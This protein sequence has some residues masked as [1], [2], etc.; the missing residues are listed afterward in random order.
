MLGSLLPSISSALPPLQLYVEI[1]PEG[2]VLQPPPG[3][4]AGPVVIKRAITLDGGGEVIVDGEGQGTVLTI[5]ADNSVVRGLHLTN[6]GYS[7]DQVDAG[8]LLQA[9]DVLIEDNQLDNNQFGIHLKQAY[10]N[11]IRN[12]RISSRPDAPSLRGDGIRLWYSSENLIEAN[13]I[14]NVRDL[15]LSNSPD[16]RIIG[17]H[18][19][20]SRIGMEIVFSPGNLVQGNVISHNSTGIV[21]LYSNEISI[22]GNKLQHMRSTSGSA[23][24]VKGSSQVTIEDNEILHCAIGVAANAPTHPENAFSMSGNLFA[25][26]DV[27]L[28]FYGEKGGHIIHNN[29][30][31]NNLLPVAVSAPT[32]ARAN[33][34]RGNYWDSYVGFDRD[35]DGIGDRPYDLR[36]YADR[37]WMD[38][39]MTRFFRGSPTLEVID[40]GERLLPFSKPELILSD[41]APRANR[42]IRQ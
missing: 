39:P 12:N 30:F 40:F 29:R 41:P 37:I 19:S 2:G 23:L 33:H 24:T 4:Y 34:W 42:L 17:N 14:D 16:N 21:V 9:N 38:R 20:N 35:H 8:I 32:S 5:K 6:S 25:Y 28:Y 31:E 26:N 10:D 22:R 36:L 1:T 15:V 11:T 13:T 18:I 3:R 7:H 27:A